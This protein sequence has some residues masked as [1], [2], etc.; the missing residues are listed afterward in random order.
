MNYL[1]FT[2]AIFL[3]ILG[4]S[5]F[6]IPKPELFS[7]V[8]CP[9]DIYGHEYRSFYNTTAFLTTW[10]T[11]SS[12]ESI[13]IPTTGAGYLYDVAWGDGTT[14]VNRTGNTTHTYTNPGTYQV[15]I[16]GS[17]PRIFFNRGGSRFKIYSVDQWGIQPWINMARAFYG[18]GNIEILATDDPNLLAVTNMAYM[19]AECD[20]IDT[21]FDNWNT[22]NV[23]NMKFMFKESSITTGLDNW[24]VCNVTD[25]EEM[26]RETSFNGSIVNWDVG[27]VENMKNMFHQTNFNQNVG[28]WDVSS[29]ENMSGLFSYNLQFNQN[30]NNWDVSSVVDMSGMFTENPSFNGDISAWD[31][32]SVA[33]MKQMFFIAY[34]FNQ[35]ISNWDVSNVQDMS[36]MFGW[37]TSF[38]QNISGWDVGSVTNMYEMFA[39]TTSFNQNIGGWDVS[40]VTNMD[41][42]FSYNSSFNHNIGNWDLSGSPSMDYMFEGSSLSTENYDNTLMGWALQAP[43]P[44][45]FHAGNSQY[46]ASMIYRDLLT[47][48]Y[49]WSITDGGQSTIIELNNTFTNGNGTMMWNDAGNWSL[50]IIPNGIHSVTIPSGF[51]VHVTNY[52]NVLDDGRCFTLYVED[53]AKFEVDPSAVFAVTAPCNY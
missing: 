53:G 37:A 33:T 12:N 49:G 19:F 51:E 48:T 2:I 30:L 52:N 15:S 29:V 43:S 17:F 5:E 21:G 6:D 11:T 35:D 1:S 38:N 14:S 3:S 24:D 13:T 9:E 34:A 50:G 47:G 44:T 23:T 18:C 4:T 42:M 22:S 25:M 36:T 46:C 16:T 39:G 8:Y 7:K 31:V 45:D 27:N 40:S 41:Y 20:N 32:S 26:F 28:N 10:Q